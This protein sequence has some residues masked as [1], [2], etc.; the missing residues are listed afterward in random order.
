MIVPNNKALE[1]LFSYNKIVMDLIQKSTVEYSM[2]ENIEECSAYSEEYTI[3]IPK[4]SV[5]YSDL[6]SQVDSIKTLYPTFFVQD[7]DSVMNLDLLQEQNV[8]HVLLYS[9]VMLQWPSLH[10]TVFFSVDDI[11]KGTTFDEIE[12][13]RMKRN[14]GILSKSECFDFLTNQNID[15]EIK[16]LTRTLALYFYT[17]AHGGSITLDLDLLEGREYEWK[18]RKIFQNNRKLERFLRNLY[19]TKICKEVYRKIIRADDESDFEAKLEELFNY[20]IEDSYYANLPK[21]LYGLTAIGRKIFISCEYT[22]EKEEEK[23][24]ETEEKKKEEEKEKEKEENKEETKNVSKAEIKERGAYTKAGYQFG[25]GPTLIILLHEI[26]HL[27]SR[28]WEQQTSYFRITPRDYKSR[29][30]PETSYGEIGNYLESLLFGDRLQ[31]LYRGG[32]KALLKISLWNLPIDK[33]QAEFLKWQ[34]YSKARGGKAC[35]LS[36]G[37]GIANCVKF[38]RCGMSYWTSRS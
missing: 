21:G 34:E 14:I 37:N 36:R 7:N 33:F 29:S 9:A 11:N 35:I 3:D 5:E 31:A 6:T 32:E 22:P 13:D 2:S 27:S 17:R 26:A 25:F 28:F 12:I 8:V 10:T 4:W 24:K 16:T 18:I 20:V 15:N 23:V 19:H 30:D 1:I 38:G